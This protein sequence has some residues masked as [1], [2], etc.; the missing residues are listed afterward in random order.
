MPFRALYFG[1]YE[2]C[3]KHML[4]PAGP[5]C[6]YPSSPSSSSSL[7]TLPFLFIILHV[8]EGSTI[9]STQTSV[10]RWSGW[11]SSMVNILTLTPLARLG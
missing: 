1:T 6:Y 5:V 3:R 10:C 11:F 8:T 4:D 9:T 2:T 7:L